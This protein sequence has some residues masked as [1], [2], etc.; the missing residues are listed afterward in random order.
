VKRGGTKANVEL[1]ENSGRQRIK[2]ED[3]GGRK[4]EEGGGE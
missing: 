3:V 2:M 1:L 4:V